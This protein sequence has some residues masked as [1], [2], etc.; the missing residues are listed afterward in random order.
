METIVKLRVF[1]LHLGNIDKS[2]A[3]VTEAQLLV[4]RQAVRPDAHSYEM[5][6]S[7]LLLTKPSNHL[8]LAL[9]SHFPFVVSPCSRSS[10]VSNLASVPRRSGASQIAFVHLRTRPWKVCV[11]LA[12][13]VKAVCSSRVVG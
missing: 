3:F 6:P 5:I 10:S 4:S 12:A 11:R 8:S 1:S 13:R 2:F 9:I 7:L